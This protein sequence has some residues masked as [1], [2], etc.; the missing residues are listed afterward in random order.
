VSGPPSTTIMPLAWHSG[1]YLPLRPN[2]IAQDRG[3]RESTVVMASCGKRAWSPTGNHRAGPPLRLPLR[4]RSGLPGL[5]TELY[6]SNLRISAFADAQI[7]RILRWYRPGTALGPRKR[8]EAG[9]TSRRAGGIGLRGVLTWVARYLS[10]PNPPANRH[11]ERSW[12]IKIIRHAW[13]LQHENDVGRALTR[14]F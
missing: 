2:P 3:S 10:P 5:P 9:L 13:M 1:Q 7:R 4:G 11:S 6:I 14:V 12:Q 8:S